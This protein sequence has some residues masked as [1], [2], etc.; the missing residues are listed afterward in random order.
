MK[1]IDVTFCK[2]GVEIVYIFEKSILL[3]NDK[4]GSI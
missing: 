2:R 4:W 3:Y 1:F